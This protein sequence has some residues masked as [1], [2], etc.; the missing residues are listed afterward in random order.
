M[1]SIMPILGQVTCVSQIF[2]PCPSGPNFYKIIHIYIYIY[3]I[4]NDIIAF[5]QEVS[6]PIMLTL[7]LLID[8]LQYTKIIYYRSKRE[9][10]K[11]G[12]KCAIKF[13]YVV[14]HNS[15]E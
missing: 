7:Q 12:L 13:T 2:Y 1:I 3:S 9:P 5:Q 14:V 4:S 11:I 15:L 8:S 6:I 10:K